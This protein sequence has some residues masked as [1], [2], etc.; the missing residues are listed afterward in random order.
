M[1]HDGRLRAY[2][3]DARSVEDQALVQMMLASPLAGSSGLREA[4]RAHAHETRDHRRLVTERLAELG[5]VRHC[6]ATR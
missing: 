6:P 3:R 1:S 2:L 4:F 5:R